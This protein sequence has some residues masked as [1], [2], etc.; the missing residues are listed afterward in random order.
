MNFWPGDIPV[1]KKAVRVKDGV[2]A[3][4]PGYAT[5]GDVLAKASLDPTVAVGLATARKLLAQEIDLD[6]P[7]FRS[8]RLSRGLS[9][10]ELAQRLGTSQS[11]VARI[12]RG[13]ENL[14]LSTLRKLAATLEV[15]MNTLNEALLKQERVGTRDA[16]DR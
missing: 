13:T 16:E 15:D 4:P 9:Q 7:T 5:I 8:L 6:V 2:N 14:S 12:E 10:T 11:H 1:R 3:I